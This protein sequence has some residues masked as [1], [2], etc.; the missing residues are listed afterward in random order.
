MDFLVEL[1]LPI[2]VSAVFVF[3]ASSVIHMAL[4]LHKSDYGKLNGE[5]GILAAMRAANVKPGEYM[6]PMC[7]SMKDMATPE[8]L[9]KLNQGPVG[10]MTVKANGPFTMGKCLGQWFVYC[11]VIGV[12]VAYVC[13]LGTA[14]GAGFSQ[15]FR[16]TS[17]AAFLAHAFSSVH[18]SIW[19]GVAW[20]TTAKFLFDGLIY[21]LVTGAAFAWLWPAAV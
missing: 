6:F 7:S 16:V 8:D 17:A 4:P 14:P 13:R 12:L 9:A 19:K 20:S 5:E 11:L 3:V 10:V 15:V 18:N 1:W 21:A 2:L